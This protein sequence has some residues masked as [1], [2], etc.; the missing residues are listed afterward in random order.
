MYCLPFIKLFTNRNKVYLRKAN[1]GNERELE[2]GIGQFKVAKLL[3]SSTRQYQFL[4]LT[5]FLLGLLS[6][7]HQPTFGLD[8]LK[9]CTLKL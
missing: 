2:N 3:K 9:I 6:P 4:G 5:S 1:Q 7:S 8:W